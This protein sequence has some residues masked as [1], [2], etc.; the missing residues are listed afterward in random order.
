M[1]CSAW[2]QNSYFE[3]HLLMAASVNASGKQPPK[4]KASVGRQEKAAKTSKI[5][6]FLFPYLK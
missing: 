1:N 4:W 5:K 2:M 6:S 3:D